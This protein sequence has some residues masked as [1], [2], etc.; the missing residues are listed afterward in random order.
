MGDADCELRHSERS[1]DVTCTCDH[2]RSVHWTNPDGSRGC[3]GAGFS[4][5]DR[6]V[7]MHCKC[8]GFKEGRWL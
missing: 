3:H 4:H 1:P 8:G 2:H 5:Q 6:G 7:V